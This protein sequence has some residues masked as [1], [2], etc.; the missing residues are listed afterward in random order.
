MRKSVLLIFLLSYFS[1]SLL[2]Q[3][4]KAGD[5]EV[6]PILLWKISGH[7]PVYS[8]PVIFEDVVYYGGNDSVFHAVDLK[9]GIEK[10]S[11]RTSAS[12]RST[13]IPAYGYIYFSNAE[14]ALYC[15]D[16]S[17]NMVWKVS[18]GME[19]PYDFADYHQSSPVAYDSVLYWGSG[20]GSLYAIDAFSGRV[21]WKFN[22]KGSIHSTPVVDEKGVYFGSFDGFVYALHKDTGR[23]KWKFKTVGHAY[24]PSGE[25]QGSPVLFKNL[26]FIGARD[27]NFYAID[28]EKGYCHWNKAFTK[29]WV[30]SSSI[31]DSVLYIGGADERILAAVNPVDGQFIWK[32][33][34]EFLMFGKP[35][36]A[37]NVLM[38]G[39]TI[40]KLHAFDRMTGN[41][42]WTI[43]TDAYKVNRFKYFKEDDSYR[44][45]I[46]SIITSN[47]QFLEVEEEL[48][49]IFS[50]P[51]IS[52]G[53]LVFTC[54][55]GSVYCYR[56]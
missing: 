24:F 56:Q 14:G 33:D 30:L 8:S 4:F 47:E 53:Y 3:K 5:F 27:Y 38:I 11:F 6:N 35:L 46:Y 16:Y 40:G 13:A 51:A 55:D 32:K 2:G 34:M 9:S 23:M 39:T 50:T 12:I 45:D 10:W 31:Y 48:G 29:G 41:D 17:G 28:K 1:V 25:V 22:A 15:L 36:F 44:D 26:L 42:L 7:L 54:T 21:T 52:S 20:S 18:G 43:S 49:G 19:S 37:G